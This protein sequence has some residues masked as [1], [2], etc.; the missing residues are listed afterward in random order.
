VKRATYYAAGLFPEGE[1]IMF[2]CWN[3]AN[4]CCGCHSVYR[5]ELQANIEALKRLGYTVINIEK[6]N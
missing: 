4:D 1:L 2:T 5:A 3:S 6:E